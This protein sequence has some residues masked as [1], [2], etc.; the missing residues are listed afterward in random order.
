[1]ERHK[2]KRR[3]KDN[4]RVFAFVLRVP[5]KLNILLSNLQRAVVKQNCILFF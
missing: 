4:T 5:D 2:S 1:M 3:S